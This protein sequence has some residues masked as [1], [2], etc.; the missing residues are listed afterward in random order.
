MTRLDV[1]IAAVGEVR[2]L[3]S[4]ADRWAI[5]NAVLAAVDIHDMRSELAEQRRPKNRNEH[6]VRQTPPPGTI[7][8]VKP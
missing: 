2:P 8:E 7:T 5:A 3:L 6:R 1:A 4:G